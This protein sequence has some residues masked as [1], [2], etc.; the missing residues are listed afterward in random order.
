MI[1]KVEVIRGL[2]TLLKFERYLIAKIKPL[3]EQESA[4]RNVCFHMAD[5]E[6]VKFDFQQ[7]HVQQYCVVMLS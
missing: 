1:Y 5:K 3:K 2:K 6:L 7:S 4:L